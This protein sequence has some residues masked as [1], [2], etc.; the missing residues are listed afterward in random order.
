LQTPNV[1]LQL[2]LNGQITP[3][4]ARERI[5]EAV[6]LRATIVKYQNPEDL[7]KAWQTAGLSGWIK[8]QLRPQPLKGTGDN[9]HAARN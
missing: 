5:A 1:R 3:P 9:R 6:S 8:Q 2:V 4:A 7:F